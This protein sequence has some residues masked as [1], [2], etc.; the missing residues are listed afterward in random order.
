MYEDRESRAML[1][2]QSNF[3][4]S[5]LPVPMYRACKDSSCCWARS[6]SAILKRGKGS[7]GKEIGVRRGGRDWESLLKV[8]E[9]KN[10]RG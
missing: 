6:L 4:V 7:E 10:A 8:M 1:E 9:G 3:V 5:L 2:V